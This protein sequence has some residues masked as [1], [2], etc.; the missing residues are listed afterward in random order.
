MEPTL[1]FQSCQ[2]L[3]RGGTDFGAPRTQAPATIAAHIWKAFA[4]WRWWNF[5]AEQALSAGKVI[6][7][8]NRD[9]TAIAL[10]K[11]GSKG[12]IFL[13]RGRRAVQHAPLSVR[14][15]YLTL[16]AIV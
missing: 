15:K 8:L 4:C 9:E 14:R 10:F 3:G 13:A 11:G 12:N 7:R 16:V 5:L 6:L 1:A 2:L